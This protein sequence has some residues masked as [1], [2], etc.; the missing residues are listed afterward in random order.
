MHEAIASPE[1]R[2]EIPGVPPWLDWAGDVAS[3]IGLILA[4]KGAFSHGALRKIK[5]PG[6]WIAGFLLCLICLPIV[7]LAYLLGHMS[8]VSVRREGNLHALIRVLEVPF[9]WLVVHPVWQA[10]FRMPL[11]AFEV[12]HL[13]RLL[14]QYSPLHYL[15]IKGRKK[16]PKTLRI[17][18]AMISVL[19]AYSCTW[20]WFQAISNCQDKTRKTYNQSLYIP[21]LPIPIFAEQRIRWW[22]GNASRAKKTSRVGTASEA[23]M[24]T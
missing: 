5:M 6:S 10:C 22:A 17:S 24:T 21:V 2:F 18:L 9:F 15:G 14:P 16:S 7:F 1:Q 19:E 20:H 4:L 23:R 12:K 8:D 13:A 3:I 11:G